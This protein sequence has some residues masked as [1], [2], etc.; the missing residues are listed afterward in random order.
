MSIL[1]GLQMR[2][3]EEVLQGIYLKCMCLVLLWQVG[4]LA[5][6]IQPWLSSKIYIGPFNLIFILFSNEF[7]HNA[8]ETPSNKTIYS[9]L[10]D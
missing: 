1:I 6:L 7:S 2:L 4:L 10:V 5:I 9:F 8:S 3:I